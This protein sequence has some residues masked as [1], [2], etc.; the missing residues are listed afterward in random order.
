M[1]ISYPNAKDRAKARQK[2]VSAGGY[3]TIHDNPNGMPRVLETI[4]L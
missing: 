2:G 3:I 1:M 4:I